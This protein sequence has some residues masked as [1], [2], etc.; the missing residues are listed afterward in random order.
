M[1]K[2]IAFLTTIFPMDE[3]YLIDFFDSLVQ[4]TYNDFDI[5]VIND[6]YRNFKKFIGMYSTLNIIELPYEN[7]IAK[8][9]EYGINWCID[10]SYDIL[11]FGDSDDYFSVNRLAKSIDL[12]STCD[13]VVNDLT[14][15]DEQG[16]LITN[17][18]SNRVPTNTQISYDFI[19]DKNIFGLSNT[20]VNIS[21]LNRV[22]FDK[23]LVA[24][25]WFFYKNLLETGLKAI[26]T[27]E[28]ETFYRQ[29]PSNTVGLNMQDNNFLLWWEKDSKIKETF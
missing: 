13:I 9:R 21:I 3:N 28:I 19:K 11:I 1:S 8:N 6:G 14:L 26:F 18:I 24:V 17:Y 7:S 29:H 15:F 23:D 27:N 25:D 22:Q 2:S 10:N 4:Q 20:A 16:I 12:L 5:I